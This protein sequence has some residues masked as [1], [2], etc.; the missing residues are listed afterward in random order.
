VWLQARTGLVGVRR[1]QEARTFGF[2]MQC[3]PF[4]HTARFPTFSLPVVDVFATKAVLP[5]CGAVLIPQRFPGFADIAREHA[6]MRIVD[7]L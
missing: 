3:L 2:D 5:Q 6:D 7:P 1:T 4:Y